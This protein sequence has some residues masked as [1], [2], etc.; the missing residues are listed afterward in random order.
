MNYKIFWMIGLAVLVAP[1]QA[2]TEIYHP[3]VTLASGKLRGIG[4]EGGGAVFRGIPYARPPVGDLRW[5]E[6][7]P[8]LPWA[9]VRDAVHSGSPASQPKLGWND[10][11]AEASREDCLYLDVWTPHYPAA[12]RLPVMV[13]FHGGAN[14][15]GSGG[16]DPLY[17][18]R[19]LISHRVVLVVVEYRL[20]ILGFF[21]H[22]ELTAESGHQAS[23]NYGLMDQVA[24][25]RWV[26][27]NIAAFGGDASRV[28]VFGQSAGGTDTA[29]LMASPLIRGLF[30]GAID[31]SGPLPSYSQTPS[32]ADAEKA[33]TE[34]AAELHA[35]ASAAIACLRSLPVDQLLVA[36]SYHQAIDVDGWVLPRPPSAVFRQHE[37]AHVPLVIGTA[38]VEIPVGDT[39]AETRAMLTHV[40]GPQAPQAMKLYGGDDPLY[41][42]L[43]DQVGS[44]LL[45]SGTVLVGEE[46][47]A[48][49]DPTWE[50]E[51]D[52]AI[53]GQAHAH[54][55]SDLPYVFGNYPT[56]G[57]LAGNYTDA[58]RA[59]S[60]LIQR[61]WTSFART[62]RPE[63]P[64]QW[65]WPAYNPRD[66]A[67]LMFGADAKV[68]VATNERAA[69][70]N[71]FR[72]ALER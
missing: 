70:L 38:A 33:G 39:E 25:L 2:Q 37:E 30:S 32:L 42:N 31:E 41:G 52:R 16:F 35:P 60:N 19:S 9:G 45:R 55:S 69:T 57:G 61:F 66:R 63:A 29:V 12:S 18:G 10:A 67:Y 71:L 21:A 17:R 22:P 59:L 36:K 49:G 4:R 44:D 47:A 5:R 68:R 7:M 54:H 11:M 13:W 8:A 56:S 53:P 50:Y 28:T 14:V 27:D 20:G 23:G 40:L 64:G 65:V 34:V 3:E 15:A 62:G 24:A 46:H 26:R 48:G 51:F 58:D 6:P 43:A 72:A 1:L